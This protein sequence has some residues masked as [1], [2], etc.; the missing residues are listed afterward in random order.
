MK[1]NKKRIALYITIIITA[2]V[3][4][5]LHA[6]YARNPR[7]IN[8]MVIVIDA[9]RHDH[10]GCY[11]YERNTTPNMDKLASEGTRFAQAI[12]AGSWTA[13][14]VPSILTGTYPPTHQIRDWNGI[15]NRE[16]GT[17][18]EELSAKGY[19][20]VFWGNHRLL[21]KIDIHAGFNKVYSSDKY[22]HD[23]PILSEY[24][25][26]SRI[27]NRIKTRY[28]DRPFFFYIH[29][30]GCHAPYRPPAPYKYM[31]LRDKYRKEPKFI[32]I[33][34]TNS[35]TLIYDRRKSIPWIVNENNITDPD[36]YISQYDGALSYADTQLQR[37][38]DSLSSFGLDKNTLVI[39]TADHGE[40]LGEHDIYFNHYGGFEENI[41]VPLIIRLPGVF[42]E[43]KIISKQ[44]SLIDIAPTI[45]EVIGLKKPRYMQGESLVAFFKPFRN[46][47][48]KYACSGWK[49]GIALRNEDWKISYNGMTGLCS[50][51]N[52]KK[53]P[54]EQINLAASRP[55]KLQELKKVLGD[56]QKRIVASAP[57]K[58]GEPLKE[59]EKQLIRSMG[60]I[61]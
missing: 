57:P 45:I 53:D 36:Y 48:A 31:Y 52:L 40:L 44:V 14:S 39:L 60:Y 27:I 21:R 20:C 37:L 47:R 51:Y 54:E 9:L 61:Q 3:Y 22:V 2:C 1:I 49:R 11:G 13:E 10:L 55:V 41:R 18:A 32:P 38:M 24:A 7:H 8:V 33:S 46:Y 5:H 6:G 56:F 29:Y 15:L 17:L 26:T 25:F 30:E 35:N 34:T 42:P 43:N 16:V 12:S 28:K 58:K 19:Q 50:L 59:E 23:K 4:S